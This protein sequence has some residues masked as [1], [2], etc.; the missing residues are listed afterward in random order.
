MISYLGM[1][2]SG[3]IGCGPFLEQSL[4]L[5]TSYWEFKGAIFKK[6]SEFKGSPKISKPELNMQI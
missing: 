3:E 2:N 1:E 4:C 5:P 6:W